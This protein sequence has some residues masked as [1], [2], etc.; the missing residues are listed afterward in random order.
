M[1]NI[2]PK[3]R[4][5]I[6]FTLDLKSCF[7]HI[8]LQVLVKLFRPQVWKITPLGSITAFEVF[9]AL[10]VRTPSRFYS[11][12]T[13]CWIEGIYKLP[14][15]VVLYWHTRKKNKL[16]KPDATRN[17]ITKKMVRWNHTILLLLITSL[18][19]LHLFLIH[20]IVFFLYS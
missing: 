19:K 7:R 11:E 8:S 6:Y 17:V 10:E 1:C 16:H 13:S 3:I 5:T 4:S 20:V 2:S 15:D 9:S 12:K 14:S 18:H